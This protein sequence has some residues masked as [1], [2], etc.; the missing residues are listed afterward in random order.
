MP[1]AMTHLSHHHQH[2]SYQLQGVNEDNYLGTMNY[3]LQELSNGD[4][5]K[6]RRRVLG[7]GFFISFSFPVSNQVVDLQP[8][9]IDSGFQLLGEKKYCFGVRFLDCFHLSFF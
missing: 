9:L 2:Q 7:V 4:R 5:N 3:V 8:I 1:L 6:A